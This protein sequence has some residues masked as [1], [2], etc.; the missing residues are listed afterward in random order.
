MQ[1][2][3]GGQVT[4]QVQETSALIGQLHDGPDAAINRLAQAMGVQIAR[5]TPV[6]G[7]APSGP[8]TVTVDMQD[9]VYNPK[10]ITVKQGTTI[11]FVNRDA[12]KHT[13]TSDTEQFNSGDI[14]SGQNYTLKLD[15]PGSYLYYCVFHGD[16][17]GVDMAG[18]IEVTP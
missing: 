4:Q 17:G 2:Q 13:V 6:V 11:V 3:D 8:T 18:T 7:D 15:E 1:A 5:P 10:T 12:A 16:K 9:F 14:N